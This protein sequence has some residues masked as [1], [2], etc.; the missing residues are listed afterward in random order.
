MREER[1]VDEE[2]RREDEEGGR[3]RRGVDEEGRRK[4]RREKQSRGRKKRGDK[5][6]TR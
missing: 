6:K 2:G 3:W 1:G 5:G 4:M